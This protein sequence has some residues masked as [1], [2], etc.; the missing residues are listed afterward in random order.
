MTVQAQQPHKM[1]VANVSDI[2]FYVTTA[3]AML[4]LG[5]LGWIAGAYFTCV[6]VDALLAPWEIAIP[7]TGPVRWLIPLAMSAIEITLFKFRDRLPRW[8]LTIGMVVTVLDFASTVYGIC[9]SVGGVEVKLF[10][11][12]KVPDLKDNPTIP[13][14][15]GTVVSALLTLGPEHVIISA[16]GMLKEVVAGTW[17]AWKGKP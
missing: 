10:T 2:F 11:G 16:L 5:V 1:Y 6:A 7:A 4:A 3:L 9:V 15:I 14:L 17:K 13:L 12:Y 8:I